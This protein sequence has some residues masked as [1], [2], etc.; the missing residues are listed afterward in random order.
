MPLE[1]LFCP[2]MGRY[3]VRRSN[4]GGKAEDAARILDI[5]D[6]DCVCCRDDAP[7]PCDGEYVMCVGEFCKLLSVG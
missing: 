4:P 3:C 6:G 7:G 2:E 1:E 5:A